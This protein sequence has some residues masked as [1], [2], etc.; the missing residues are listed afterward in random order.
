MMKHRK[1]IENLN[2][3]FVFQESYDPDKERGLVDILIRMQSECGE[4]YLSNEEIM[5]LILDTIAAS[6]YNMILL[7]YT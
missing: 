5:G 6:K 4:G 2:I 3:F 7:A 1:A